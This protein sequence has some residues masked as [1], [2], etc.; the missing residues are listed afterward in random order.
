M[1][2]TL[3]TG[4]HGLSPHLETYICIL[5]F[6]GMY[7]MH[8][9]L[10]LNNGERGGC[11]ATIVVIVPKLAGATLCDVVIAVVTSHWLLEQR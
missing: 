8:F 11:R 2:V 7:S 6:I 4:G 1:W 10:G 3:L 5:V 9:P